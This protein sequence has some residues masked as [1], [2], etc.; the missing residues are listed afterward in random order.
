VT[1]DWDSLAL[2]FR[3]KRE[4]FV[5]RSQAVDVWY[6]Q[7]RNLFFLIP[8]GI[9]LF[10]LYA[11][12]LFFCAATFISNFSFEQSFHPQSV[13]EPPNE[14]ANPEPTNL[15]PIFSKGASLCV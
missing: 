15:N 1:G 8:W 10:M 13:D 11:A 9:A 4:I 5:I 14:R 3:A 2:S 12:S 7:T 6:S